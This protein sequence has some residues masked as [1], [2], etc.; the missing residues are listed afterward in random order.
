MTEV[1]KQFSEGKTAFS[2]RP[3]GS[4][5]CL[6][7][8]GN[9]DNLHVPVNTLL[10]QKHTSLYPQPFPNAKPALGSILN[11]CSFSLQT[12]LTMLSQSIR[13][14]LFFSSCLLFFI[15]LLLHL[16]VFWMATVWSWSVKWSLY[17]LNYL[18]WSFCLFIYL[19][20]V[21]CGILVLQPWIKP[22]STAL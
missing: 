15:C 18:L 10:Q 17:Q 5:S 14:F 19:G 3:K 20:H 6:W 9:L 21:A 12:G 8:H 4:H 7:W 1:Q 22:T 11:F 16:T 2:T 13:Y